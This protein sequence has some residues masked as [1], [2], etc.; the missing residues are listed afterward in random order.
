MTAIKAEHLTGLAVTAVLHLTLLLFL[1]TGISGRRRRP[2]PKRRPIQAHLVVPVRA[3]RPE[4]NPRLRSSKRYRPRPRRSRPS[5][6]VHPRQRYRSRRT[7]K[8]EEIIEQQAEIEQLAEKELEETEKEDSRPVPRGQFGD[9]AT[10]ID[11]PCVLGF[12]K[13]VAAYKALIQ[14]KV[15]GFRRPSFVSAELADNLVTYVRVTFDASGRIV[16]V[17]TVKSSGNE[18]FDRAAEE[19]VRKIG[20][21]GPPGR[22]VMFDR[23]SGT[24]RAT[25][26]FRIRMKAR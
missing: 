19:F 15:A 6:I 24:Y 20:S 21:F 8:A 23:K 26:S 14:K 11:D 12:D 1:V 10:G 13:A 3:G 4:G 18:R 22:C 16:S 17:R 9:S 7:P 2:T 25:R 5:R